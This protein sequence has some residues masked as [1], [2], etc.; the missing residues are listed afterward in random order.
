MRE[1]LASIWPASVLSALSFA[2]FLY[3]MWHGLRLA[4]V[5]DGLARSETERRARQ[6]AW[7][8]FALL[9]L[10]AL[11]WVAYLRYGPVHELGVQLNEL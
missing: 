4:E 7:L 1:V 11:L 9:V 2:A 3:A 5:P 10:A 8:G 6:A